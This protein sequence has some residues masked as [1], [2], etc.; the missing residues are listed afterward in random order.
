MTTLNETRMIALPRGGVL[1]VQVTDEFMVR[2]SEHFS[3]QR[4]EVTDEHVKMFVWGAFNTAVDK[5]DNG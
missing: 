2:V 5:A 3:V 4:D 1:E